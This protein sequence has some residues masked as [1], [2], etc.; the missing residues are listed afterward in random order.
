MC[1][2]YVQPDFVNCRSHCPNCT[3]RCASSLSLEDA[4]CNWLFVQYNFGPVI[5]MFVLLLVC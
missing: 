3:G 4:D 2:I 1:C 5:P